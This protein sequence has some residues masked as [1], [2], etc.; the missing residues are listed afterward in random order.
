MTRLKTMKVFLKFGK[1]HYRTDYSFIYSKYF[2]EVY[3][4]CSHFNYNLVFLLI[5]SFQVH[6][7][8]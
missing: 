2:I 8:R 3:F 6:F 7:F 5:L 1:T 4:Y